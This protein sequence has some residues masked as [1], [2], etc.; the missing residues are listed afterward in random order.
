MS[1]VIKIGIAQ[2]QIEFSQCA[3]ARRRAMRWQDFELLA[4]IGRPIVGAAQT[5]LIGFVNRFSS[6]SSTCWR[7]ATVGIQPAWLVIAMRVKLDRGF[8]PAQNVAWMLRLVGGGSLRTRWQIW[9]ATRF[10]IPLSLCGQGGNGGGATTASTAGDYVS[11]LAGGSVAFTAAG[12]ASA[13]WLEFA[14]HSGWRL[15][16][17]PVYPDGSAALARQ[18]ESAAVCCATTGA[19]LKAQAL[20]RAQSHTDDKKDLDMAATDLAFLENLQYSIIIPTRS[21]LQLLTM[22]NNK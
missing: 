14:D 8:R 5:F 4:Q 10:S 3:V 9:I 12:S 6:A 15:L 13:V 1:A 18:R 20:S 19:G 11:P 2:Q 21:K 16:A 7:G 22:R 17:L